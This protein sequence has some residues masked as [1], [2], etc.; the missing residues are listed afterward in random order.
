MKQYNYIH[1][2]YFSFYSKSGHEN[3]FPQELDV[4]P[5]RAQVLYCDITNESGIF[6]FWMQAW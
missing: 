1:A 5:G 6:P 4:Y 2:L 3:I